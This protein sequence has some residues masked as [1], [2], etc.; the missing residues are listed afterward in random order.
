MKRIVLIGLVMVIVCGL[1]SGCNQ[2]SKETANVKSA[3][4]VVL[5]IYV[6]Q[7][8][9]NDDLHEVAKLFEEQEGVSVYFKER[10]SGDAGEAMV[11]ASL[12][13]GDM[14][15][16]LIY[17]SGGLFF[18]LDPERYFVDLKNEPYVQDY[19]E[20]YTNA[21]SRNG[22]TFGYPVS[23]S[24]IVGVLY[25]KELYEQLGLHIPTNWDEF[26][27]NCRVIQK[28]GKVPVVASFKDDWTSQFLFIG[29]QY[30]VMKR[31]PAFLKAFLEHRKSFVDSVVYKESFEKQR[32]LYDLKLYNSDY[33]IMNN[34]KA[35]ELMT[36]A[37]GA[38]YIVNSGFLD[39]IQKEYSNAK[40]KVGFFPIPGS[41]ADETGLTIMLP[42][43]FYIN[44]YSEHIELSKKWIA[45][46]H[47]YMKSHHLKQI[48]PSVLKD[49]GTFQS[50]DPVINRYLQDGR[51]TFGLEFL[52]EV[53]GDKLS[54]I[55]FENST[56]IIT[57]EEAL[58]N[59]NAR[60]QSKLDQFVR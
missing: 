48:A 26:I 7:G 4:P 41:T 8:L 56:G 16:L 57:P 22:M 38:H 21:V 29:S 37:K 49:E 28:A 15:D 33:L 50:T 47:A 30:A 3:T 43:S 1:L 5:S 35:L 39:V 53:K 52:S 42:S 20:A 58:R 25:N 60:Y 55:S 12:A 36:S 40:N 11:R 23:N 24:T 46:F 10:P 18:E 51:Y 31:E 32:E 17:N 59:Y 13:S 9:V 14:A 44:K 34:T 6:D 54:E 27:S 45:L 2:Q 19:I